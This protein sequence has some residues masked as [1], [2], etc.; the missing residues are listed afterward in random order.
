MKTLRIF[1]ITLLA[2]YSM[3]ACDF[4]EKEPTQLVPENYF[5]SPEEAS[6]F[7]T[8]I[9]AILSQPTFYG[10]DYMYLQPVTTCHI[11][12]VAGSAPVSLGI[13]LQQGH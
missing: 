4:L 7:L 12:G 3:A 11:L 13:D 1:I 10:G 9:Y 2:C 5:N 6:S 8:G